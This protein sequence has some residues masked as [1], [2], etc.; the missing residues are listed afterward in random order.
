MA[1]LSDALQ[2][3]QGTGDS[4]RRRQ[5]TNQDPKDQVNTAFNIHEQALDRDTVTDSSLFSVGGGQSTTNKEGADFTC[6]HLQALKALGLLKYAFKL[7]DKFKFRNLDISIENKKG[8]IRKWFN[9][10]DN[11][12]G[13]QKMTWPYGYIRMTEGMDGDHVDCFI[14][15]N[16]QAPNVYVITTSRAPHFRTVDEQKCM[17]GFNSAEEAK[18]AFLE[19]Y[20]NPK[21][22]RDMKE[23]TYEEFERKAWATKD[24]NRHKIANAKDTAALGALLFGGGSLLTV[25]SDKLYSHNAKQHDSKLFN[26]LLNTTKIK[27]LRS[28]HPYIKTHGMYVIDAKLSKEEKAQFKKETGV[29]YVPN[30]VIIGKDFKNPAVLAHEL[31]HAELDQH[32]MGRLLQH[33]YAPSIEGSDSMLTALGLGAATGIS[34]NK[35]LKQLG[36]WSPLL[37]AAPTLLSEVGASALAF[38]QLKQVKATPKQIAA[39][40]KTLL[41]A[42]GTYTGATLVNLG[43]SHAV[44]GG[45]TALFKNAWFEEP[46]NTQIGPSHDAVPGDYLGLPRTSLVGLRS[47]KGE[48]M[49]PQDRIL[50]AFKYMDYHTDTSALDGNTDALP[51]DPAV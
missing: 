22:F 40:I 34:N 24:S 10:Q 31:G 14:G 3:A 41:P 20:N 1:T 51:S 35:S 9:P 42:L 19:N 45:S 29:D 43:I 4:G 27:I 37:H 23:L 33:R 6:G 26:K 7:E 2:Y 25:G 18:K 28:D 21:F 50:N 39:A 13:E 47:V 5:Y 36:Q 44:S 48:S 12:H 46:R 38:K 17:L 30:S 8:S 16:E 15:P 32:W 11:S 49:T